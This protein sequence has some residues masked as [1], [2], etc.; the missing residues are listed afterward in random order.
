M[1]L[2]LDQREDENLF[3]LIEEAVLV[4]VEN[5]NE[6]D[7]S[8]DAEEVIDGLFILLEDKVDIG[9]IEDAFFSEVGITDGEPYF[10]TFPSSTELYLC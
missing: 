1:H 8:L 9:F 3:I 10:F 2:G 4:H 5:L 6:I 7:C